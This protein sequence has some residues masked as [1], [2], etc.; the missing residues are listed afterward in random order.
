LAVYVQFGLSRFELEAPFVSVK[1]DNDFED[2]IFDFCVYTLATDHRGILGDITVHSSDIGQ[3]RRKRRASELRLWANVPSGV[4]ARYRNE[5]ASP[6]N[7]NRPNHCPKFKIAHLE[8]VW[9]RTGHRPLRWG[10]TTLKLV[11]IGSI[12]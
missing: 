8:L 1:L 4:Q 11:R 12:R 9:W 2:I 6:G 3:K 10:M 5:L 7:A